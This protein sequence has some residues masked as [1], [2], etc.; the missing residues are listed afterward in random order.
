MAFVIFTDAEGVYIGSFM[1][2]GFWSK[3]DPADQPSAPTFPT[4]EDAEQHMAGWDGGRPAAVSLVPVVPDEPGGYA[5]IAACMRA[6]LPEWLIPDSE[7][8][9]YRPI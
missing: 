9:N 8:L 1:G 3:L 2:L 5:S 6:G 4:I 7:T